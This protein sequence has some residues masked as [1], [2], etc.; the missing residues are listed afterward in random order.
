[1][2]VMFQIRQKFNAHNIPDWRKGEF[3]LSIFCLIVNQ[4]YP[5]YFSNPSTQYLKE[6]D[7]QVVLITLNF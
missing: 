3:S 6:K 4:E 7:S 2:N 1:M 5:V